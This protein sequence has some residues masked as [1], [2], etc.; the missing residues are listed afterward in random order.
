M[1]GY[2]QV[3]QINFDQQIRD[4]GFTDLATAVNINP[5]L[6]MPLDDM[7]FG[8][9]QI[10]S[11]QIFFSDFGKQVSLTPATQGIHIPY[12]IFEFMDI[13]FFNYICLNISRG[14]DSYFFEYS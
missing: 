9:P 11:D 14:D 13:N 10:Q 4:L 6:Q 5:F 1:D 12:S 3:S 2:R 7:I 8:Q